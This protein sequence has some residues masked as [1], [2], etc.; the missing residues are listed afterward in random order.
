[1]I[2]PSK[3]GTVLLVAAAET[4]LSTREARHL[5]AGL[6]WSQS[7]VRPMMRHCSS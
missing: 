3:H 5:Q 1:M 4:A 7:D 6:V 2:E